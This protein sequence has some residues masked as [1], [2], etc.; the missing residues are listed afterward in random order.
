MLQQQ[1]RPPRSAGT[2]AA[3]RTTN[4]TPCD[5]ELHTE[6]SLANRVLPWSHFLFA[7]GLFTH[8]SAVPRV[9]PAKLPQ[10]VVCALTAR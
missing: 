5:V 10:C 1:E 6:R 2:N 3:S 4:S 7:Y 8:V 9:A